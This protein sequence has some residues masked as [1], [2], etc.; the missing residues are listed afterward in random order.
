VWKAHWLGIPRSTRSSE[1]FFYTLSIIA[2]SVPSVRR[3]HVRARPLSDAAGIIWGAVE[4]FRD[5]TNEVQS[6]AELEQ[7]REL[8][9]ID[10]LTDLG[11]RR[12][13]TGQ[14]DSAFNAFQRYGWG[15]GILVL[16]IDHFKQVNDGYGHLVGD[17]IIRMVA[18]TL[19]NHLRASDRL[20]RWGGDE[21]VVIAHY[22]QAA[23]LRF[24]A[25]HLG[26]LVAS[27]ALPQPSGSIS[28]T[29][30]IGGTIARRDDTPDTLFER[31]DLQLYASKQGGRNRV[32]ISDE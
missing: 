1:T 26:S 30:S 29:L 11:N 17:K 4:T 14:I 2:F 22:I 6:H 8:A 19:V 16:D 32:S 7:L 15:F 24:I 25:E 3:A 9:L 28:V 18:A 31:A 10:P 20:A 23:Q 27:A 5:A 13:L 21:F 12:F